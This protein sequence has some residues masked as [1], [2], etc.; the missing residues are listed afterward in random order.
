MKLLVKFN[1]AFLAVFLIGLI[2]ST[3][4]AKSLLQDV[5]KEDVTDRARLLMEKANAVAGYTATQIKPLLET[6]MTY[7]FL[8]QSVPS[9]SAHEV[10][11]AL[12]KSYPDYSYKAAMLNPTNPRDK[13]V[14]WEEDVINQF[15][16]TPDMKEFIGERDTPTGTALYIARPIIIKNEACLA[17]HTSPDAAP[18]TLV[19]HYG[20]SNGFGWKTGE[21]LGAQVVSVPMDVPMQQARH[22]LWVVLGLLTAVFVL[23]GAALNFMLWKLVIQPVSRLS[24]IADK[25]SLGED[26]PEFEV[27]S[28]DEIG[29]LS[30]SFG[31]MRKSLA[32][33]M[34]MLEG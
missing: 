19:D 10:L 27:A 15:K 8:P 9:Y 14:S 23:I 24:G 17:C 34:Q 13:A 7:T 21:V 25:V 20:P 1:L 28:K 30:E 16:N 12:K 6:Q 29:V 4:V 5:A 26:A 18:K 22:E 33:A 31:R 2:A 11:A 3:L 32:T